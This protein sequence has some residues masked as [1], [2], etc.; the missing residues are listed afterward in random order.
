MDG[1]EVHVLDDVIWKITQVGELVPD[2]D[3]SSIR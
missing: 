1:L 2:E 3:D